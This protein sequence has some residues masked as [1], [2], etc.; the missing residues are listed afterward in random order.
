MMAAV[1]NVSAMDTLVAKSDSKNCFNEAI[2]LPAFKVFGVCNLMF[3]PDCLSTWLQR[4]KKG[5]AA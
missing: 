2:P 5:E 4:Y 1:P 3:I